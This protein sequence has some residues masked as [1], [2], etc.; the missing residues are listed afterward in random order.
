[1]FPDVAVR[2]GVDELTI[3]RVKEGSQRSFTNPA[4]VEAWQKRPPLV[5]EDAHSLPGRGMGESALQI[6]EDEQGSPRPPP[7][8]E[9]QGHDQF[10]G[11]RYVAASIIGEILT[12][13]WSYK[14]VRI[15]EKQTCSER[16]LR[17]KKFV[18][19]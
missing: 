18:A 6:R 13:S 16:T 17:F 8:W 7:E 10:E 2:E 19:T 1:M 11:E 4:K 14:I 15:V 9:Q 12:E 3:R 5:D